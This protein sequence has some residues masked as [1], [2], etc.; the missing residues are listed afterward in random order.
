MPVATNLEPQEDSYFR[1]QLINYARQEDIA[2]PVDF[3]QLKK[4]LTYLD[5]S[6]R[7]NVDRAYQVATQA[8]RG[9]TRKTGHPYI[10]HPL[11]VANIL[12]GMF[13]D[14]NS[15]CAALLHDVL[16]D[17]SI[18]KKEL[19]SQFGA[20]VA[21]IVDG[22]SKFPHKTDRTER[23]AESFRKLIFAV[24]NDIRV[25]FVKLADRLHNMRTLGIHTVE[26]RKEIAKETLEI[27]AKI[28]DQ[29]GMHTIKCELE[30]LAFA[31]IYPVRWDH[32][33]EGIEKRSPRHKAL[34]S[35][36]R[37]SITNELTKHQLHA[38]IEVQN[39]HLWGLYQKKLEEKVPFDVLMKVLSFKIIVDEQ[40]DCYRVLGILHGLYPYKLD[41]F[42]D[43][44]SR[45]KLNGYQSL[46]TTLVHTDGR[47]IEVYI[48]TRLMDA[49]AQHGIIG[50]WIYEGNK[51]PSLVVNSGRVSPMSIR[52][53]GG[54]IAKKWAMNLLEITSQSSNVPWEFIND[55]KQHLDTRDI[56]V[57]TPD[58]EHVQ[59]PKRAT[60]MDFA[61]AVHTD[62]GHAAVECEVNG[63]ERPLHTELNNGDTVRILTDHTSQ[64]TPETLAIVSTVKA[65]N[66][67]RNYLHQM[68]D[69]QAERLGKMLVAY[70]LRLESAT[71]ALDINAVQAKFPSLNIATEQQFYTQIGRGAISLYDAIRIIN[72]ATTGET[73][74]FNI[75]HDGAVVQESG[76]SQVVRYSLCCG[77]IPGDELIGYMNTNGELVI[78]VASCKTGQ[79][80]FKTRPSASVRWSAHLEGEFETSLHVR[81]N[82]NRNSAGKMA[83]AIYQAQASL[84]EV[85]T[86]EDLTMLVL[87]VR[88]GDHLREVS[89]A[90][91]SMDFV[92]AVYRPHGLVT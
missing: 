73:H 69:K 88:N 87:S 40:V 25:I 8:H 61:Y 62:V 5:D 35:S 15:I 59:L 22:V 4:K 85:Q 23:D 38:E 18:D 19:A 42:K 83:F 20:Q 74:H 71:V 36:V 33:K 65:K 13:L 60:A 7:A 82:T 89:R 55:I 9:Q 53:I 49:N 16:E 14:D 58:D 52:A 77:P 2:A 37:E 91:E 57:Y 72:T 3:E 86:N 56:F 70:K 68:S 64:P 10:T 43:Y 30:D 78:H 29:L 90:L 44:I 80:L 24:S 31:M 45:P 46:H 67:I 66:A 1:K 50:Q 51:N 27:H 54:N 34:Q 11:A 47:P 79:A 28:A 48:R 32:V 39:R 26:K 63:I 17:S 84:N 76:R 41:T 81:I 92:D 6:Q 12:A 21:E 75:E